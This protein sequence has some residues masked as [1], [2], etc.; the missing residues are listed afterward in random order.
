MRHTLLFRSVWSAIFVLIGC[1]SVVAASADSGATIIHLDQ[2]EKLDNVKRLGMNIGDHTQYGAAQYMKN[3]IPNPGFEAGEYSTVFNVDT[4]TSRIPI[5]DV[6]EPHNLVIRASNWN[7]T[8]NNDSIN[9]GQP[10][11]FWAN[12]NFEIPVGAATGRNGTVLNSTHSQDRY[13]FEISNAGAWPQSGD[14]FFLTTELP[15]YASDLNVN[16]A[17]DTSTT[18][19]NSDGTQSLR[20]SPNWSYSPAFDLYFDT[21]GRDDDVTAGKLIVV[22]GDWNFAIW[23]KAQEA[24]AELHIRFQRIDENIFFDETVQLTDEWQLIERSFT[25]D[26]GRDSINAARNAD[27]SSNALTFKLTLTQ[28]SKGDVWVDDVLLERAGQTNP[29]I[30][31]DHYI[32]LLQEMQPGIIRN[33][34][35]QLGSSLDNQLAVPF[36]RKATGYSPRYRVADKFHY[37]LHEFLEL[38]ELVGA[39]PWYVIPPTFSS[40]EIENLTAYLTAPAG[41]HAYADKRAALGQTAPW[42]DTFNTIHLELGNELWAPND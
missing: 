10:E 22:D 21:Y 15:G 2:T 5:D 19:P 30:F 31:S 33:W 37:S 11:G 34:G 18:R 23:A 24:D 36:A 1:I 16:Y 25:V 8:W 6:R 12:S 40:A 13:T 27:G 38:C 26:V 39:E 41:T 7:T 42:T 14:P 29:T 20:L 28:P 35:A 32:G 9:I 3:L 17:A 4:V